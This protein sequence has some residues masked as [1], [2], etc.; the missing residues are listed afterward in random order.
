MPLNNPAT[1]GPTHQEVVTASRALNSTYQNTKG[2]P[3]YVAVTINC[4]TGNAG[5]RA[6]VM[7]ESDASNPPTTY[8]AFMGI[9]S[10]IDINPQNT[11]AGFMVVLPGNYYRVVS[12]LSGAGAAVELSLWV[13]WY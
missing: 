11:F 4:Q 1:A 8:I 9:F 13:E 7:L 12:N 6:R 3:L 5:E 2:V 10:A